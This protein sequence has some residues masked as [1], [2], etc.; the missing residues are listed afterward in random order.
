MTGL[1]QAAEI[2]LGLDMIGLDKALKVA[3]KIGLDKAL[4]VAL[5]PAIIL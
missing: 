5:R 1:K 3:H 4:K 2:A